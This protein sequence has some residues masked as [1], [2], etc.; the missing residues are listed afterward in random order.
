MR[1][2]Q[3]KKV[4]GLSNYI[5]VPLLHG[6]ERKKSDDKDDWLGRHA[7]VE[8]TYRIIKGRYLG[9]YIRESNVGQGS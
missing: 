3:S 1:Q 9:D 5:P 8:N 4:S 7:G 2:E 6:K